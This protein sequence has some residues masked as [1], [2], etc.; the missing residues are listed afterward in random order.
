[1]NTELVIGEQAR[2]T[3]IFPR[4]VLDASRTP[5]RVTGTMWLDGLGIGFSVNLEIPENYPHGV[6]VLW[7]DRREIAPWIADRHVFTNGRAC[8]CVAAEYR[9][10][11]PRGSD[12][13]DFLQG[14][15]KPYF[16]GQAYYQAHGYWPPE[17]ARAHGA[18]GII[19]AYAEILEPFGVTE[20]AAIIG[21]I[22]ALAE[23]HPPTGGTLCP[24]GSGVQ[25]R[26][27]QRHQQ[28]VSE[29]RRTIDVEHAAFDYGF[30][31]R[32]A[33]CRKEVVLS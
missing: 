2:L 6:P 27:C 9:K 13:T 23:D 25:L 22:R 17:L 28:L 14:L 11:W 1:M 15:V 33:I 16:I 20:Y 32:E 26:S 30:V 29:L 3:E 24:C 18:T 4:L 8:L 21:I 19:E 7:C 5:A 10:Y 12:I 31:I